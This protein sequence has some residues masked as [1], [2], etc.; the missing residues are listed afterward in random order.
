MISEA[1]PYSQGHSHMHADIRIQPSL[2]TLQPG[3]ESELTDH[4]L[5]CSENELF[6]ASIVVRSTFNSSSGSPGH[7]ETRIPHSGTSC[8]R[9]A[10]N[11]TD[12][13]RPASILSW[14]VCLFGTVLA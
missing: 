11:F 14:A 7:S 5:A 12:G 6:V 4:R 3:K 8:S 10:R 13:Q 1:V 9:N 2:P